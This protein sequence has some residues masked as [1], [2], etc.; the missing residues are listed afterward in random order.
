M[1]SM[2]KVKRLMW[3]C[4]VVTLVLSV[5]TYYGKLSPILTGVMAVVTMTFCEMQFLERD[6]LVEGKEKFGPAYMDS[7]VIVLVAIAILFA[8][9][10]TWMELLWIVIAML[11][12]Y[13][14]AKAIVGKQPSITA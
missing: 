10:S 2:K 6:I 4:L 7:L 5:L 12:G 13:L 1:N 8:F 9:P 11:G 14:I 3:I